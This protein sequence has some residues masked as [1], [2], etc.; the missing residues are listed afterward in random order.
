[1][2]ESPEL[3]DHV[4]CP[5]CGAAIPTVKMDVRFIGRYTCPLCG[6]DVLLE[7]DRSQA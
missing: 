4:S 3:T 6:H 7:G 5:F 1:M 2:E